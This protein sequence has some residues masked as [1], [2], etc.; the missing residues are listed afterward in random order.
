MKH[1]TVEKLREL[2]EAL[3]AIN[4]ICPDTDYDTQVMRLALLRW[5]EQIEQ[6]K[7]FWSRH[8]ARKDTP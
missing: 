2:A 8:K 4:G 3:D 1:P 5:A 7:N 6:K